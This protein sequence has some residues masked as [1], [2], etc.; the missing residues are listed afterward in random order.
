M[1]TLQQ[2]TDFNPEGRPQQLLLQLLH[3]MCR[4]EKKYLVHL[5]KEC[6]SRDD[7]PP[8]SAPVS[9]WKYSNLKTLSFSTRLHGIFSCVSAI[10]E[11]SITRLTKK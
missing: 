4:V 10:L 1:Y 9:T 2:A 6:C 5:K 11:Y 3:L 7:T 8:C